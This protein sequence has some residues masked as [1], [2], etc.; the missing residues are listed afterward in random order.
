MEKV[1]WKVEGM[2]CTNC[3]LTINKYLQKEGL[4]EVKV[5]FIGGDVSFE[6]EESKSKEEL[7]KGIKNLGYTVLTT[8]DGQQP[9]SDSDRWS[10]VHGPWSFKNHFQRFMFCL[11]F[12]A[13]LMLH[14]LPQIRCPTKVCA[15][16][17]P[18]REAKTKIT[19]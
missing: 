15:S 3:A 11:P 1:E 10:I 12:T 6:M 2:D 9:T 17:S 19:R 14:M 8:D 4:K 13:V 16:T 7:A 5:N 18:R